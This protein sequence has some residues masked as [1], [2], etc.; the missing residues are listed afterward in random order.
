MAEN[1][2]RTYFE[3]MNELFV[4]PNA[5]L[6]KYAKVRHTQYEMNLW[7]IHHLPLNDVDKK[8]K[9]YF[10]VRFLGEGKRIDKASPEEIAKAFESLKYAV[11][12]PTVNEPNLNS[13]CHKRCVKLVEELNEALE[14][15][16]LQKI[17]SPDKFLDF[18][19]FNYDVLTDENGVAREEKPYGFIIR[20]FNDE[21]NRKEVR[22]VLKFLREQNREMSIQDIWRLVRFT[23]SHS[24]IVKSS[25]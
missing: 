25:S 18:M 17:G 2:K 7:Q 21:N 23:R 1:I 16:G 22:A 4:G 19:T 9:R 5:A 15:K 20:I 13:G 10:N 6:E 14:A 12:L 24:K 11:G 3:I 8:A